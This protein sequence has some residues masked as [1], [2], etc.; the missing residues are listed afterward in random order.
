MHTQLER[1]FTLIELMIVIAI[2]GILAAIAVPQYSQYTRQAIYVEIRLA[3]GPIKGQIDSCYSLNSGAGPNNECNRLPVG[4]I[5]VRGQVTQGILNRAAN[6]GKV[7]TVTL[8]PGAIPI[9]TVTPAVGDGLTAADT[10]VLT[11]TLNGTNTA[12]TS[13]TESGGGCVQGYC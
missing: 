7:S 9:I 13:W 6:A 10:F 5:E 11:G 2:I 12:V 1:G 8:T 4:A 3:A